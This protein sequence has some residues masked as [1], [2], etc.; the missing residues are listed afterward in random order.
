M[1][2]GS[3]GKRDR[4]DPRSAL[5]CPEHNPETLENRGTSDLLPIR[6]EVLE[7]F[8]GVNKRDGA[9]CEPGVCEDSQHGS[10]AG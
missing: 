5:L 6:R 3:N 4:S 8:A 10:W 1:T 9:M 2:A 7:G